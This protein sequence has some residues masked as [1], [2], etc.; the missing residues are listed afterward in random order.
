MNIKSWF[1]IA[2]ERYKSESPLF[3][4]KVQRFGAWLLAAGTTGRLGVMAIPGNPAWVTL[5]FEYMIVAGT[6]V[7][8]TAKLPTTNKELQQTVTPTDA[9]KIDSGKIDAASV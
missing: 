5:I 7:V 4:R 9:K 3:F 6:V 2:Y 1:Q 8:G